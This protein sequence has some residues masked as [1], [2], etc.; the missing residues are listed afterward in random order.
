MNNSPWKRAG[1]SGLGSLSIYGAVEGLNSVFLVLFAAIVVLCVYL[2]YRILR[3]ERD[4]NIGQDFN[5]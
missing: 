4:S 2:V 1:R 5:I 3:N